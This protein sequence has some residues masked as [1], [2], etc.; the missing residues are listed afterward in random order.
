MSL[1]NDIKNFIKKWIKNPI[2]VAGI[3]YLI[4][5]LLKK[6]VKTESINN[7]IESIK[8]IKI[9][10]GKELIYDNDTQMYIVINED[11]I[12]ATSHNKIDI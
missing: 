3:A 6:Y 9:K 10:D 8:V 4:Y 2:V 1:F 5:R 12:L 7:K 11:G